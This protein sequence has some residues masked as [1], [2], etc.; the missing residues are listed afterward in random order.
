MNN[1]KKIIYHS[2][3]LKNAYILIQSQDKIDELSENKIC[4]NFLIKTLSVDNFDIKYEIC[5][6][7]FIKIINNKFDDIEFNENNI[8]QIVKLIDFYC[9]NYQCSKIINNKPG[10][11]SNYFLSYIIERYIFSENKY[12]EE[13]FEYNTINDMIMYFIEYRLHKKFR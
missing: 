12:Y 6:E 2:N 5:L 9:L 3:K 7:Y 10:E 11:L 13:L 4:K 1:F 8:L